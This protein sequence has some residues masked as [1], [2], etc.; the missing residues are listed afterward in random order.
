MEYK[1]EVITRTVDKLQVSQDEYHKANDL[2][3]KVLRERYPDLKD[4]EDFNTVIFTNGFY[5]AEFQV[6]IDH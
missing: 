5:R 3:K 6:D 4:I 1:R 2:F